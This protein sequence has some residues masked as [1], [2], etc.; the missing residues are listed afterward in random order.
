MQLLA[1][2][3]EASPSTPAFCPFRGG[4]LT[5]R[6]SVAQVQ[7]PASHHQLLLILHPGLAPEMPC[8]IPPPVW[9]KAHSM[10]AHS[11]NSVETSDT[12]SQSSVNNYRSTSLDRDPPTEIFIF[13]GIKALSSR[14]TFH[15]VAFQASKS[16]W[17]GSAGGQ[18]QISVYQPTV[19]QASPSGE[20]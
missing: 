20:R 9:S 12:H 5:T 14:N 18:R 19:G 13:T 7:R 1:R 11:F 16:S 17:G 2:C 15:L 6:A 4:E 3:P 8:V 10:N